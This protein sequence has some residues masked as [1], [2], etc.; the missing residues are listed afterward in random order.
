MIFTCW[1]PCSSKTLAR[2]SG[3][4]SYGNGVSTYLKPALAIST[5]T[6]FNNE[7]RGLTV[8]RFL[9]F[10]TL[11]RVVLVKRNKDERCISKKQFFKK[12]PKNV[13]ACQGVSA[14]NFLRLLD[15]EHRQVGTKFQGGFCGHYCCNLFPSGIGDVATTFLNSRQLLKVSESTARKNWLLTLK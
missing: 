3:V 4:A 6:F 11:L 14:Q 12:M 7:F 9:V 13:L 15:K 8:T 1:S 5:G 2:S 10:G